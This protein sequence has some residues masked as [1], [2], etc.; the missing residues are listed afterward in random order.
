MFKSLSLILLTLTTH[1]APDISLSI[2]SPLEID[3]GQTLTYELVL[4]NN[5]ELP[6]KG[7]VLTEI[8]PEGTH[9]LP[10]ESTPGWNCI[11]DQTPGA[12]CTLLTGDL[13][14]LTSQSILFTV[15]LEIPLPAHIQSIEN[16]ATLNVPGDPHPQNNL[17]AVTIPLG[18]ST[19]PKIDVSVSEEFDLGDGIAY[20]LSYVNNGNQGANNVVLAV[21]LPENAV[22]D[23]RNS[24]QGWECLGNKCLME[25]LATD[26]ILGG[27]VVIA[28]RETGSHR[29]T[30]GSKLAGDGGT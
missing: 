13:P 20:T 25:V 9:F 29:H 18:I 19:G 3:A 11:P 8:V 10:E 30:P 12:R 24:S 14:A 16:T 2:D 5:D 7:V 21:E 27:S 15:R 28:L 1:T 26:E 6:A 17:A 4:T 22:F 23:D